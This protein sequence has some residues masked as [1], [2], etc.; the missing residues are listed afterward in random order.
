MGAS[1]AWRTDRRTWLVTVHWQGQR[2][3]IKVDSEQTAKELVRHVHKLELAG[4]NV[5]DA[6]RRARTGPEPVP[7]PAPLA[8]ML[9]T[10]L[11]A[12]IRR[13]VELGEIRSSTARAYEGRLRVWAFAHPL[14][15]GRVL[16]DLPIDAVTRAMVGAVVEGIRAA[17]RSRTL[18]HHVLSPLRGY[19]Q[20]LADDGVIPTNPT[21]DLRRFLGR[22]H[23]R[24]RGRG[25]TRP[26]YFSPDELA[27]LVD[28]AAT[29]CPR[30]RP[31]LLTGLCA[32]LR[33]GESAALEWTDVDWRRNELHV[34]RTVS[35]RTR[36]EPVK[37]GEA[38]RVTLSPGLR[39]ALAA[40]QEAMA[41]E[42]QV[43]GWSPRSRALAFPT[44][45]GNR[46]AYAYWT[47]VWRTLL[48]A[49]G[50]P[51]RTYHATRHTFATL[52]LESG[53][54]PRW[55]Q[56]QLGH[57]TL[58]MTVDIYGHVEP[59]RHASALAVLDQWLVVDA[60]ERHPTPPA[61]DHAR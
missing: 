49:T 6:I 56:S 26:P 48:E 18:L 4:V 13:Q 52:L 32:G 17:G 21:A 40:H 55:V 8:P 44:S 2:E 29:G 28:G 3:R 41:L 50:L 5:L 34:Q 43:Q 19:Y 11:S 46:L 36:I 30:W 14:P 35:D 10:A 16:G 1:Y 51:R 31:F 57:A 59:A 12:W 58:A 61:P 25:R 9:R 15:D 7:A 53:A 47:R 42:A 37:D 33:W 24:A 39:E 60:P 27:R 45:A 20:A 23:R 38:R 22:R 54:D